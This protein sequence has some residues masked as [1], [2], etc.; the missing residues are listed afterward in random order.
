MRS[1]ALRGEGVRSLSASQAAQLSTYVHLQAGDSAERDA[2]LSTFRD[3]PSAPSQPRPSQERL[4]HRYIL[5]LVHMCVPRICADYENAY[6]SFAYSKAKSPKRF[7]EVWQELLALLASGKLK[8]VLFTGRY[9]LDTL[10]KGLDDLEHRR[11]WGKAVIR[12]RE[13]PAP[14]KL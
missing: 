4:R 3:M 11:T 5:G 7:A 8:P 1:S 14:G 2:E 13:P 9:T 6:F 12:V 10:T